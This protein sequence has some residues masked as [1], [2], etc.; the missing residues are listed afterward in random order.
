[1]IVSELFVFEEK[2]HEGGGHTRN[3]SSISAYDCPG[4]PKI[5]VGSQSDPIKDHASDVSDDNAPSELIGHT[6]PEST[7]DHGNLKRRHM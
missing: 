5:N 6:V 4:S 7:L 1:M 3:S 2:P